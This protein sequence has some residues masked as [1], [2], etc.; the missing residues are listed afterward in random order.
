MPATRS[1]AP[2]R[3]PSSQPPGSC[4][5]VTADS[6]EAVRMGDIRSPTVTIADGVAMPLLGLGT[7]Q[8]SDQEAYDAVRTALDLGYRLIDTAT[9]YRNEAAVGRAVRDSGLARGEVFLTTKL[10]ASDAGREPETIRASLEAMGLDYLDLWLIHWPVARGAG[11]GTW[12]RFIQARD[13]GLT[14]AIGVSNYNSAEIDELTDAT[15]VVPAVN[16]IEWTPALYDASTVA[17]HRDR[18]VTL[19]GYSP[20]KAANLHEPTLLDI[21]KGHGVTVPQVILRWHLEHGFIAIPKS[22]DAGR[23]AENFDVFDFSLDSDEVARI[24]SLAD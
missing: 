10:R 9:M 7:W 20:F 11:A 23:I 18:G 16:Q 12:Q 1:A 8:A 3:W 19:E 5:G 13:A 17:A 22:S 24:D 14:R 15:G 2:A 4:A 21:A 6:C